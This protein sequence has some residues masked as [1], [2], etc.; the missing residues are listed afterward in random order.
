MM[1]AGTTAA[2]LTA[3]DERAT[4]EAL[5]ARFENLPRDAL[6]IFPF[7]ILDARSRD[8]RLVRDRL[9]ARG[10]RRRVRSLAPRNA[11]S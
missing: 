2:L 3:P 1:R 10:R 11:R 7:S 6:P 4:F 9:A 8:R 5:P